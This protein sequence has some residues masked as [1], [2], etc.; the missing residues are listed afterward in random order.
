MKQLSPFAFLKKNGV[1][2]KKWGKDNFSKTLNHL[3]R[4]IRRNE[5]ILET[6]NG[7]VFRIS[8][9]VKISLHHKINGEDCIL[10]EDRQVFKNGTIRHRL[11]PD[12]YTLPAEKLFL[13]ENPR[14]GLHRLLE[15]ELGITK[16]SS[17]IDLKRINKEVQIGKSKTYPGLISKRTMYHYKARLP[18]DLYKDEYQEKQD[19][20][21]TH[22]K[23]E[24]YYQPENKQ[25]DQ[26]Q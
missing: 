15:E 22:F 11:I 12:N 18:G 1:S 3:R 25:N 10:V 8:R 2:T 7:K 14:S 16:L 6:M 9:T 20:Y 4:E 13:H 5:C 23:W 26:A 24:R 21:I 19:D 17:L